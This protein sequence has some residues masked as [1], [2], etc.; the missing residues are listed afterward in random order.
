M[1]LIDTPLFIHEQFKQVN[2][3]LPYLSKQVVLQYYVL[4]HDDILNHQVLP[5]DISRTKFGNPENFSEFVEYLHIFIDRN[6]TDETQSFKNAADIVPAI[7]LQNLAFL[8]TV[9]KNIHRLSDSIKI[10]N[11]SY[12]KLFVNTPDS[13]LHNKLKNL[14]KSSRYLFQSSKSN[15]EYNLIYSIFVANLP[16]SWIQA[17]NA[18]LEDIEI[19][20]L[21]QLLKCISEDVNFKHY[22]LKLLH[23]FT[24]I[25]ADNKTM[26]STKSD[27]LPLRT[28]R[29]DSKFAIF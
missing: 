13:F 12:W 4:F 28:E 20:W 6:L 2:I 19:D 10:F 1:N 24:L 18:P 9:N 29:C 23:D 5:C 22:S 15:D 3:I 8:L 14:F 21:R 17:T 27:L 11:S 16:Q 25:P 7:K 26:F